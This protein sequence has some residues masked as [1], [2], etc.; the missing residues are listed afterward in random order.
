MCRFSEQTDCETSNGLVTQD[1]S[2]R[3]YR[4]SV[5]T[6][7]IAMH[8]TGQLAAAS[9]IYQKVLSK[10]TTNAEALH[11]LGVRHHQGDHARAVEL[12]PQAVAHRGMPAF[13]A[14]LAEAY[15]ALGR[16]ER[17]VGC[18]RAA[19]QLWPDYPEALCNLGVAL[20]GWSAMPRPSSRSGAP[21]SCGPS[22]PRRTTTWVSPSASWIGETKRWPI[23]AG[24][25][26]SSR[27]SPRREPTS[28]R[29]CSTAARRRR[30]CRTARKPSASSPTGA[31]LHHNLGNAFRVLGRLVEARAAYLEALRLDPELAL[32]HAHLGLTLQKEG[33]FDEPCPG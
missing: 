33:N 17:A 14:N 10:D 8:Q 29:C 24:P 20:Q 12:M 13:H 19:L 18:C 31:A 25:S 27:P 6:D 5:L 2:E 26:S 4:P 15:R 11:L 22:S 30:P 23:F 9:Q 32:A 7:A 21:W 28:A 1:N 16:F 3:F